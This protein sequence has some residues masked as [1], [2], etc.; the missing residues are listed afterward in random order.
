[1]LPTACA[2]GADRESILYRLDPWT[3]LVILFEICGVVFFIPSTG[4]LV[5]IALFLL[6]SAKIGKISITYLVSR[7]KFLL[8]FFIFG[9]LF[10]FFFTPGRVLYHIP[11]LGLTLTQEGVEKGLT[12]IVQLCLLAT[13]SFLLL[14]TTSTVKLVKCVQSIFYPFYRLGIHVPDITLMMVMSLR[15][16]PVLLSEGKRIAQIQML[17]AGECAREKGLFRYARNLVPLIT[18]IFLSTMRKAQ[19]LALAVEQRGYTGEVTRQHFYLPELHRRDIAALCLVGIFL[20]GLI[21]RWNR[22][23]YVFW[24]GW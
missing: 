7:L 8:W 3:K 21:L 6:I 23:G 5:C 14:R 1:M 10:Y 9:N 2:G 20:G 13:A 15:F 18:P 11:G 4:F 16:I 17:R 22:A 12:L 24:P 19:I